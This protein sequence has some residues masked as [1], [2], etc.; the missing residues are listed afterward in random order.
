MFISYIIKKYR[1]WRFKKNAKLA[2]DIATTIPDHQAKKLK[3][4]YDTDV[5]K[6]RKEAGLKPRKCNFE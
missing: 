4:E 5:D 6:I 1:R 3:E 2:L